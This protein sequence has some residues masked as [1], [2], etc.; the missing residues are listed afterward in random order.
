MTDVMVVTMVFPWPSEAFAGVEV[1]ALQAAGCEVRVRA[2]RSGHP[3]AQ[4]LLR[5]WQLDSLD[6]TSWTA[7]SVWRGLVFAIRHPGMAIRT[8]A[9]LIRHGWSRPRLLARCLLL[10][11]RML[12]V[13]AECLMRPPSVLCLYWGHYPSVLAYMAKRWLPGVHVAMSLNAYDLV[14]AFPP[15][16]AVAREVDSLWTI[17]Q[18]NLPALEALGLDPARVHVSLHGIDLSQV[19]GACIAKADQL[20]VTIARLE[21]NKG[22]DDAIRAFAAVAARHPGA[23]LTIVGEGPERTRLEGLAREEGVA[24]RVHFTG[25]IDH[26]RVYGILAG[27]S[28]LLLL[29]R[30]PAERLPNAVKE[31]MACRCLCVVT[32]TPGIEFLLGCLANPM[33]VE[34]GD[35]AG[36]AGWLEAIIREPGRIA[37]DRDAAAAFALKHLDAAESAR[38]RVAVWSRSP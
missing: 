36:A 32:R 33:V 23:R 19:P 7:S 34:Q 24:D 9:W 28:A 25:G 2:L 30:S 37:A 20:F 15:S 3:R 1:R 17:A 16:I 8:A 38:Q 18:A 31:A 29:S 35:W 4:E 11:P 21:E 26:S 27:A 14:Y 13:F 12:A 6:L 10:M 5:D 22:V